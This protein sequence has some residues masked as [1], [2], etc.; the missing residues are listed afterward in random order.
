MSDNMVE[1]RRN[2]M[3]MLREFWGISGQNS[4]HCIRG[5]VALKGSLATDHLVKNRA[6]CKQIT[7]A[8]NWHP[9][10]LFRRHV[11]DGPYDNPFR[12]VDGPCCFLRPAVALIGFLQ[13][14]QSKVEDL[15]PSVTGKE[16]VLRF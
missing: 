13:F 8:V 1:H 15:Q 11:A 2:V 7:A 9:T 6:E 4:G 10:H 12:G 16:D 14:C 3:I 5:A